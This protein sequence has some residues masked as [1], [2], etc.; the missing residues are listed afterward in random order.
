MGELRLEIG[1]FKPGNFPINI[2]PLLKILTVNFCGIS[3]I[4]Q[5]NVPN[6]IVM[7]PR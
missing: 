2:S 6:D 3:I 7:L 4:L 1:H 5:V